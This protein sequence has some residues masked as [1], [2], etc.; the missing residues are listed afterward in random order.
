MFLMTSINFPI[1]VATYSRISS[2]SE[3]SPFLVSP[4]ELLKAMKVKDFVTF[5]QMILNEMDKGVFLIISSFFYAVHP[6]GPAVLKGVED[7]LGLERD[8]LKA[9]Y[10]VLSEYGNMWSSSVLFVLDEMRKRKWREA[11]PT[12]LKGWSGGFSSALGLVSHWRRRCF[13]ALLLI[14]PTRYGLL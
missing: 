2:F 11:K 4:L 12:Q 10:Q 9:S 5:I 13:V 8:K 7:N 14:Q 3:A 6:G 1:Y